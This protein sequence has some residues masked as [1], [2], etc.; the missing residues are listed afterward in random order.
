MGAVR[1]LFVR[2]GG[3]ASGAVKGF[4]DA[5]NAGASAEKSI[6]RSSAQTKKSIREAFA[7]SVPSIREYTAQVTQTKSAHQTASQN[8]SRLKDEISRLTGIYDTVKNATS[9]LDLTKPLSE[10]VVD[11]EKSLTVIESKRRKLEVELNALTSNPKTANSKR[12]VA[13]QAEL[14]QLAEKSRFAQAR[15]ADLDRVADAVGSSNIGYASA[16]G[17]EQLQQKIIATENELRTTQAIVNETKNKL[18]RMGVGVSAW[19]LIKKEA[20]NAGTA[21]LGIGRAFQDV[22]Q[23]DPSAGIANRLVRIG[24]SV[25][26]IPANMLRGIAGGFN[27]ISTAIRSIPEIPRRILSGLKNIGKSA[28]QAAGTGVKNLWNG[29]KRLGSGA[30]HRIASLPGKLRNIGRSA[31]SS[32]GGLSKMVRSIRNIGIASLGMR[33]ASG[34]FGQMR[35]IISNYV[36]QNEE[37]NK[38]IETMKTQLGEALAPAINIVVAAMQRLMPIV[39]AVSNGINSIF[40]SLFGDMA[41]TSKKIE[42]A[43][44][45]LN[46]YGFD[47]INK[48]SDSE[49]ES[50]SSSAAQGGEQSA[51]VTKLTDWL[52]KLKSAFMAGDWKT[53]GSTFADGINSVFSALDNSAIG[54]K[55]GGVFNAVATTL[56]SLLT[57]IDFRAIGGTFGRQMTD[58][59]SAIDWNTVGQVVGQ[60]FLMLPSL[61]TG[62][63]LATDWGVVG[64]SLS[65]L[66]IS[67]FDEITAWIKETDWLQIGESIATF[68]ASIDWGGIVSS[69]CEG[70]G[71]ALAGLALL[72]WGLIKDAWASVVSWWEE[73]AYKDG[74]FTMG[75]LLRGIGDVFV[76]IGNWLKEN[77]VDPFVNGFKSLFDIHSHSKLMDGLGG[78]VIDGFLGGILDGLRGIGNW[79]KEKVINPFVNGFKSLRNSVVD[80]V[81]G[82]VNSII[83]GI[84]KLL[85]GLNEFLSLGKK[86]GLDLSIPTIPEVKLPRAAKG[87]IVSKA[88]NL[89]VGEDGTEAVVPLQKHTEWIDLLASKLTS[90]MGNTSGGNGGGS[91][92]FQFYL[93]N[94]KIT[95]YIVKDINQ[96]TR[97]NGVCPIHV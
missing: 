37:L 97:E 69:L 30:V 11:A 78:Y 35:S 66:L 39:T 90:K 26:Q 86:V 89:T 5:S 18:Q 16:Q 91:A 40:K 15:L 32:T 52:M 80:V 77:V 73:V 29:L 74:Q 55:L 6:K 46:T 67:A 19:S 85:G 93:G 42:S 68:I 45:E 33:V 22:V 8:V 65:S 23:K 2:I 7:S 48:E 49:S 94:R 63:I 14:N 72:V 12:T 50:T 31:A 64:E 9:G 51:L 60:L 36:S 38:T 20:K 81:E 70:L 53:L 88:T 24:R 25:K 95:E 92:T 44:E 61:I 84:N 76:N 13:L 71:A 27:R 62:W 96:L 41:A 10:L 58:A 54:S 43:T 87:T 75:G 4:K 59:F 47:Q 17:L 82:M 3:D 28:A 21:F 34:L 83:R 1:N 56:H 79:I 57:G